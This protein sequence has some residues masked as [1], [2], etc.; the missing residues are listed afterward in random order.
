MSSVFDSSSES[1]SSSESPQDGESCAEYCSRLS[2]GHPIWLSG[3]EPKI[4]CGWVP[5]AN[6]PPLVIVVFPVTA[7]TGKCVFTSA[8]DDKFIEPPPFELSSP[9]L[10]FWLWWLEWFKPNP[11]LL[12]V[13]LFELLLPL[14][15]AKSSVVLAKKS[16]LLFPLPKK[17]GWFDN[18]S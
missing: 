2:G 16:L 3:V 7:I 5:P 8:V 18:V 1:K 15:L 4:W 11:W 9:L 12:L 14:E 17:F 10:L 13:V 6:P